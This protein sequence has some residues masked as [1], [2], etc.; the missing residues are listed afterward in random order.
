MCDID[1]TINA[2]YLHSYT[3]ICMLKWHISLRV[4]YVL[5]TATTTEEL[6]SH[7]ND[8]VCTLCENVTDRQ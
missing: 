7:R 1:R 4:L 6:Y 3:Y 8:A 5:M 2:E